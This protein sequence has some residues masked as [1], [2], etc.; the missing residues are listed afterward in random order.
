MQEMEETDQIG[1]P[2]RRGPR[3]PRVQAPPHSTWVAEQ[4]IG[5]YVLTLKGNR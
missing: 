2:D 3:R 4:S 5:Q 1:Q